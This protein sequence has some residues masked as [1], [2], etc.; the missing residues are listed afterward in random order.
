M[1]S[2]TPFLS[3]RQATRSLLV[4]TNAA[5]LLVALAGCAPK[6]A[7]FDVL[8][9]HVCA[10]T[11]SA[12]TWKISG[13]PDL[14][15]APP[16]K[17]LAKQPLIYAPEID[18][19]FTLRVKRWPRKPKVS[20]TEVTVYP[21]TRTQVSDDE[22]PFRLSC[23]DGI[24]TGIL[25]RPL[26]EWDSKLVV[27]G[28]VGSDDARDLTVQH[29]GHSVTLTADMPSTTAFQGTPVAGIW[30]LSAPLLTAERCGSPAAAPP[31]LIILT[32]QLSCSR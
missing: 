27:V 28:T 31:A 12:V 10:R 9:H 6:I 24:L 23:E 11:P 3:A 18:T 5:L 22:L 7:R 20:E 1:R 21:F 13:T 17:P 19:V 2:L 26:S 15:L 29:D 8:P 4:P 14:H 16:L 32:A 25:D 30:R